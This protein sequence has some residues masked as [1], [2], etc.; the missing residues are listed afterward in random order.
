MSHPTIALARIDGPRGAEPATTIGYV[1]IHVACLA[2]LW[3]GVSAGDLVLCGVSYVIR[4][5]GLSA[6]YHRYFSHRAFKTSRAG[7]FVLALLGTLGVQRGVLWWASRHRHHHRYSDTD[8]DIHSP[9]YRGFAYSHSGWFLDRRNTG[10]DLARV[11]DLTRYPELVWLN[12]WNV[13]PVLA[14]GAL[15]WLMFGTSGFVWGFCV[16]TVLLWHGIHAI[17]SFGH[18][19]GGYR[20]FATTDNSRNKWFLGLVLLGEGWHNNH[21]FYPTSARTGHRWWEV[22]PVYWVLAALQR[23]GLVWDVRTPPARVMDATDPHEQAQVRHFEG[24]LMEL[25]VRLGEVIGTAPPDAVPAAVIR[26]L[27][28]AVEMHLDDFGAR[29]TAEII[30][31]PERLAA[32]MALLRANVASECILRAG[33][34]GLAG[35]LEVELIDAARTSAFATFFAGPRGGSAPAG[36]EVAGGGRVGGG[37]R[38]RA[39]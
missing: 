30:E 31:D 7:Q 15:L 36:L 3:T 33:A 24:W 32:T 14:Y 18:R 39:S 17:G 6:G 16:S 26:P 29:A 19:F 11:Q 37:A 23:V 22:D 28:E 25:R 21:H 20:R 13:A 27:Q 38:R 4:M 12:D 34:P 8:E 9:L 10:T 5:F 1:G 35:G 2:A